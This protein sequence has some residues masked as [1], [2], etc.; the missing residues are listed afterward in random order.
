VVGAVRKITC[1]AITATSAASVCEGPRTFNG[2]NILAVIPGTRATDRYI[3]ITAHYDHVCVNDGQ[4][5][6][7]ADDNASGVATALE[8]AARRLESALHVLEQRLTLRLKAAGDAAGGLF[9]QDR[10][11]L[12]SE[13]DASRAREREL[14]EAGAQASEAL[15][16]AIR[17]IRT[18][19]NGQEA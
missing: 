4:I 5:F 1:G 14:E 3:V 11:K 17:E 13:L 19:L 10:A 2:I 18:A 6:N 8:I 16:R 15:G 7:G 12:A 9:D